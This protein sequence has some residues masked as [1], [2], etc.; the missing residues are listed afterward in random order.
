MLRQLARD[1]VVYGL[2]AV[3]A[4]VAGFITLPIFARVLTPDDIGAIDLLSLTI[5]L[6]QVTVALEIA[7]G[8]A[9]HYAERAEGLDRARLASTALGFSIATYTAFAIVGLLLAPT[10]ASSLLGSRYTDAAYIAVGTAWVAGIFQLVL[11]QLRFQVRS[12]AFAG[13]NLLFVFSSASL[14]VLFVLALRLGPAGVMAGQLVGGVIALLA[15]FGIA[16]GIS[17]PGLH[18]PEL[19]SMLRFSIPLVPSSVGVIVLISVD[20]VVI[21]QAMTLGDV[22]IFGVAYRVAQLTGLV[23]LAVQLALAPLIYQRHRE[24]E[25]PR[26][27]ARIFRIFWAGTLVFW[28]GLAAFAPV[29]ITI[30]ATERY[31]ASS[32]IVPLLAGALVL[33]SAQT[34]APGLSLGMRTSMIAGV[35]LTGAALNTVLN[36]ALVPQLGLPAAAGSTLVSAAVVF[37]LTVWLGQRNY[38]VPFDWLRIGGA[39]AISAALAV[40][41]QAV[42]GWTIGEVALR[43]AAVAA[44]AGVCL[45]LGLVRRSDLPTSFTIRGA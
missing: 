18:L 15:A 29:L 22:G 11:N 33:I 34:F 3:L 24:A 30:V 43:V 7:Q 5:G 8:Y 42:T 1:S 14:S 40:A 21:S 19:R 27:L 44:V 32:S 36:V 2:T 16:R 39:V 35:N 37:G 23:F 12:R 31:V 26:E 25:T 4:R 38:P 13:V 20:R 17:R 6:V 9:R 28:V 45:G 41:L 10:F